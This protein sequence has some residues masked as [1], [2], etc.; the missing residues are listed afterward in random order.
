VTPAGTPVVLASGH[1]V[2]LLRVTSGSGAGAGSR[3]D[4]A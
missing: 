3:F 4:V 1:A 2:D